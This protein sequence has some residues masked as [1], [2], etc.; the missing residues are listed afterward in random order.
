[1]HPV[2]LLGAGKIGRA[3]ARLLARS[4]DYDLL[5]GDLNLE[6]LA[7]VRHLAGVRTAEVDV[8]DAA[9]LAA[10]LDGRRSVLSACTFGVN[11]GIAQAA[12]DTGASYFDLT[13]DV[14]ATRSIQQIAEKAAP[15]QV[16]MPQCGLAPGFISLLGHALTRQFDRLDEVRLRVGALPRYPANPLKYNL[17]WSTES[18]INQYSNPCHVIEGGARAEARPL[19]GLERFTLDG[20]EYEAFNTS[21]GVGTLWD[22][23]EGEVRSLNY[24]TIRYPGHRDLMYFL[25]HD[26][27]LG[28]RRSLLTEI[29]DDAV[30]ATDQDVVLVV[31]IVTGW[32]GGRFTQVVDTRRI[33]H[34]EID[35]EPWTAIQVSTAAAACAVMD[36]HHAGELPA[37][38]FV[39]QESVPLDR[40]L[41]NRF[42]RYYA[43]APPPVGAEGEG[44]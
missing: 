15:G 8:R 39:R 1:L 11:P 21:G 7:S 6:A 27:R 23:L 12:L 24:K 4:G 25:M 40:F 41:A 31:V 30:P 2:L 43:E 10:A 29:L 14:G 26:M 22:T 16:F 44:V 13:E 5:V 34:R 32:Q 36:L 42:G 17:T 19:E 37:Q 28:A 18:L 20:T 38:G 3:I 33:Y 35:G 9:A